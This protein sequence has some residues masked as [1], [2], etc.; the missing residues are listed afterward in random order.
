MIT[1]SFE[2]LNK[3]KKGELIF[4]KTDLSTGKVLPNTLIEIYTENNVLIFSGRTD[5]DGKIIISNLPVGKYFILEKEAPEGYM[6]AD[7]K[8]PFEIKDNGDVVKANMTNQAIEVPNTSLNDSN[9]INVI[10]VV[11]TLLGIAYLIYDK[12]KKK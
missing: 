12:V 3:Y 7:N 8:I 1:K 2:I 11:V 6:L 9:V 10:G 4:T 5:K